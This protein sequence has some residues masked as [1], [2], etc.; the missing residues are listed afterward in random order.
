MFE[1]TLQN[2]G[3]IPLAYIEGG[4][5]LAGGTTTTIILKPIIV[6]TSDEVKSLKP[7]SVED[8]T[9]LFLSV[10]CLFYFPE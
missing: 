4:I 6:K 8:F 9:L 5:K 7:G 3:Q 1:L 2:I 10:I